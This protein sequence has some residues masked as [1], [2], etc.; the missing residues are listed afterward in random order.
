MTERRPDRPK[1]FR[2]SSVLRNPGKAKY[3]LFLVEGDEAKVV[4]VTSI[5]EFHKELD[6]PK[7][8]LNRMAEEDE[9]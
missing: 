6:I 2:Y 3:M 8:V 7:D 9:N 5:Q 4:P 1:D